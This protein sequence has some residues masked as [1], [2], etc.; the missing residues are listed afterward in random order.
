MSGRT[1]EAP[2][3]VSLDLRAHS[4]FHSCSDMGCRRS[5]NHASLVARSSSS[6]RALKRTILIIRWY[7]LGTV[8][9]Q[10]SWKTP[11]SPSSRAFLP[12][13]ESA[14]KVFTPSPMPASSYQVLVCAP[15]KVS[16][17]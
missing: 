10:S 7:C 16:R 13:T 15:E 6:L 12:F 5:P 11:R 2:P 3:E 1:P 4:A 8:E 14:K 17:K 9:N